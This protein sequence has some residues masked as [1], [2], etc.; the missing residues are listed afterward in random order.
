MRIFFRQLCYRVLKDCILL[1]IVNDWSAEGY[2]DGSYLATLN[3]EL[4]PIKLNEL[5]HIIVWIQKRRL[6]VYHQG[7]KVIDGPTALPIN[8]K[9]NRLRFSMWSQQGHPFFSNLKITT[10]APDMRNKLLTEGKIISYGIYFDVGKDAVKPESNG[11]LS[12]IAKVLTENNT[13]KIKIIGH[14]NSDGKVDANLILSKKRAESVKNAL[15]N[16]YGIDAS[17]ITTDGKGQTEPIEQNT[18]PQNKAINRKVE[19]IKQ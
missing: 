11:T 9:Y 16:V 15:V 19:F 1:Q 6:R 8:A 4:A 12:E 7:L 10:A 14:T 13:V 18:T 17:R 2:K 5:N 3:S